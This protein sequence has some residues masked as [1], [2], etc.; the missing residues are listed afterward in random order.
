MICVLL[1]RFLADVGKSSD[2]QN[3]AILSVKAQLEQCQYQLVQE[4][5]NWTRLKVCE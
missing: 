3:Q 5:E 4:R 2:A 1:Y